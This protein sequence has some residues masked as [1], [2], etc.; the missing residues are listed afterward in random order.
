MYTNYEGY[1][2]DIGGVRD[3]EGDVSIDDEDE[4]YCYS[5]DGARKE[6]WRLVDV[7]AVCPCAW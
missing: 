4:T 1:D 7:G 2:V 5:C 3:G 6:L